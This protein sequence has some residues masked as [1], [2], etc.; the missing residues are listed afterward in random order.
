M[1][2]YLLEAFDTLTTTAQYL[3][4]AVYEQDCETCRDQRIYQRQ[5]YRTHRGAARAAQRGETMAYHVRRADTW[6][7]WRG[8]HSLRQIEWNH[9]PL[10][11]IRG[12]GTRATGMAY[13]VT[14]PK[15]GRI[16]GP[17]RTLSEARQAAEDALRKE[18]Q[19][20]ARRPALEQEGL[21][22]R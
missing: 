9:E 13:T 7:D 3:S 14:L 4:H 15:L 5:Y 21:K 12:S 11:E 19:T 2:Q 10:G 6:Q 20:M 8:S 17:Y 22:P 1:Q 16:L 18:R